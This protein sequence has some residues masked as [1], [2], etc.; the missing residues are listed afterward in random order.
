MLPPSQPSI[1]CV[2]PELVWPYAKTHAL[3]PSSSALVEVVIV[4]IVVVVVERQ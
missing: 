1:V 3:I 2:L 4:I